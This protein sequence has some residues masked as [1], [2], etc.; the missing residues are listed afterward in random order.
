M[1]TRLLHTEKALAHL[2][3]AR[4]LASAAGF[5]AGA[6]LGTRTTA[7]VALIPAWNA[8]LGIFAGSRFF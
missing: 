1:R 7:G 3:S 5:S 8:N 2:H 4:A 6:F